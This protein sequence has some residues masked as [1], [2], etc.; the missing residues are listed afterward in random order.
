MVMTC[1]ACGKK[2]RV[3]AAHLG[4][5][6][7]CGACKTALTPVA[8]PIAADAATF[9]EIVNGAT[10]PVLVD[11]WAEWC[12]P[13]RRAAPEVARTASEM[14]GRAIVL[15]VDT[16]AHPEVSV[17]YGVQGIP[18]F[19]VLKNG[20]VVH[21]QAGLVDAGQMMRWLADA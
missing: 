3:K 21:Q 14:A 18:N 6:T 17:R 13:C 5:S 20:R 4:A 16:D 8:E 10:V 9:D 11:F 7:R 1:K 12:A 2:N 15:K 19:V